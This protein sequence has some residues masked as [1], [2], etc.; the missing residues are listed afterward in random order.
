MK[1]N[2]HSLNVNHQRKTLTPVCSQKW[3]D[4]AEV[5]NPPPVALKRKHDSPSKD[6]DE[7]APP[8]DEPANQMQV[9]CK[10]PKLT[11][12]AALPERDE[13]GNSRSRLSA[14]AYS[15]DD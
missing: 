8:S 7:N 10:N 6:A 12:D 3:N 14:F 5:S 2:L 1:L 13:K 4:P 9:P 15:G 11:D